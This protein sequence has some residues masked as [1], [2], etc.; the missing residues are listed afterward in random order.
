MNL[1]QLLIMRHELLLVIILMVLLCVKIFMADAEEEG[2]K[3][4]LFLLPNILLTLN[5]IVGFLPSS[6]GG[7]FQGMYHTDALLIFE[8]NILNIGLLLI[9][10][11]AYDW[12]KK[13]EDILEFYMLI[14]STVIGMFF[15]ISSRNFLMFYLG[16]E[17]ATIPIA[18]MA[19]YERM[20][21]KSS[22]AG[23]KM[24]LSSAFSSGTLLFGLSMIYGTTGSMDFVEVSKFITG[25]PLQVLGII[26]VFAGFAFKISIVP[27]HLWTADVYEGAPIPVTAFLS[28]ISKGAVIFIFITVLQHVFI[29]ITELMTDVL[30]VT[31]VLTMTIGNLFAIRQ[32][33]LKR[34]LA[35]SSIAQAGYILMG[36]A[37]E[38]TLGT[39]SVVYFILIYIFSNI[40]AFGVVSVISATTG[41][42]NMDDYRGLYKT[43]P[44]L[45]LVM[46][47][48]MFSL[49]GIPPVAGFFGKFF[50][51]A[52][53]AKNGLFLLVFLAALNTVI[54]LYYYLIVVKAMFL[55]KSEDPIEEIKSSYYSKFCLAICSVGI[56]VI[57]FVSGIFEFIYS[58]S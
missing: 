44:K 21:M 51:F 45:S 9:S 57:G 14:I 3:R 17:L 13:S 1:E 40:A 6:T 15:M 24:I 46:L 43:N 47:L 27:F 35:F 29:H 18:V 33:N 41:K 22:E 49:A 42:E 19:G 37:G 34:F 20:Q 38:Q 5:L 26:F 39:A 52:A 30:V 23:L 48:A 11:Q 25:T 12:L 2:Q 7:L 16:L 53:A 31:S 8:K 10:L 50:L 32:K 58:I 56:I 36:I 4:K 55:E 54:S 28:V